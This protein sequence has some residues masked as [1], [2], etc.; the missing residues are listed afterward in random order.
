MAEKKKKGEPSTTQIL[1]DTRN[2][3]YGDNVELS[4]VLNNVLTCLSR[5]D[6]KL[7]S[8][9]KN[10]SKNTATLKQ[11]D[12]KLTSLT[13]RVITAESEITNVKTRVAELESSSQ[14]TSNLYDDM[15]EKS[16][17][18]KR[19]L[20]E[21]KASQKESVK[22]MKNTTDNIREIEEENAALK[23]DSWT[24]SVEP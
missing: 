18:L 1:S 10:T 23:N 19:D 6:S 13:S 4:S 7:V 24:C 12:D 21:V 16:D 3:L 20:N 9:E 5:M 2:V 14:G 11:L 17:D 15:K 22:E 8:I